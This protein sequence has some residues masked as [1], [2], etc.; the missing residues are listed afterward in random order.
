MVT[1][2][3]GVVVCFFFQAEDGIRDVAVT[4]VQTCAL[5]ICSLSPVR[6]MLYTFHGPNRTGDKEREHLHEPRWVMTGPLMVLGLLT[7]VGGALNLPELV[8]GGAFL[9]HWLEPVTALADRMPPAVELSR[10]GGGALA[11]SA[12][13]VAGLGT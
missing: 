7:L 2:G 1:T 10:G 6:L 11:G 3:V 8:R 12:A 4:G 5:P 9:H 13:A